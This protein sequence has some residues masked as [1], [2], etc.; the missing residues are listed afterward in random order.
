ME[1]EQQG[2]DSL[3]SC[4]ATLPGLPGQTGLP[5][6]LHGL[7]TGLVALSRH[8]VILSSET[9]LRSQALLCQAGQAVALPLLLPALPAQPSGLLQGTGKTFIM[10]A[11][12][13]KWSVIL[14]RIS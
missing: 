8:T 7:P 4:L 3:S 14:L 1:P 2:L 6:V 9:R 5:A 10:K 11:I 12:W 13:R